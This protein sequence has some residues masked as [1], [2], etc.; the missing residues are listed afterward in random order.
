MLDLENVGL[1]VGISFLSHLARSYH[2]Y[3]SISE[4]AIL[5]FPLPVSSCSSLTSAI[6]MP[7]PKNVRVAAD[8]VYLA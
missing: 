2:I 5:S 6:D 3:G 7:D 1:A 8:I 4:V